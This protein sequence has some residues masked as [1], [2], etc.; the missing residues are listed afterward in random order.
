M[1]S[2]RS[3]SLLAACCAL[4]LHAAE[5]PKELVRRAIAQHGHNDAVERQYT[6]LQREDIRALDGSGKVRHQDL[7]TY[8]ITLCEGTPY[9]RLIQRDDKPLP[10][11]EEKQQQDNLQKSID[12]RQK[13]TPEQR[14]QR[15][16]D[17]NRKRQNQQN[18]LM[19]IPDAFD[20]KLAGEDVIN[21]IPVWVV[22]GTPRPGYKSKSKM[23]AYFLK[24]KGRMWIAKSDYQPVK[25]E[26]V[27]LDT[28]SIGAFLIRFA[29]GGHINV[30][31]SRVNNEVWL[32]KHVG[33]T[34]SARLLLVKG[35]QLDAD[36][37]FSNYKKFSAESRVV[38]TGQ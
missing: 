25:M 13:E 11:K 30:E 37:A 12:Q 4:S 29:K 34:G 21:G 8:D 10:A 14:Q 17:W 33:M 6:F 23:T 16:A 1:A 35:F 24:V 9:T 32:P 26:A 31:F 3:I 38:E 7:R 19:E 27:T 36:F 28:I 15:I 2:L 22:D 20:F 5:D 18:E